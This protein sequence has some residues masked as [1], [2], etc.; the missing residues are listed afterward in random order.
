MAKSQR[1]YLCTWLPCIRWHNVSADF[2]NR[3]FLDTP[4]RTIVHGYIALDV[5]MHLLAHMV[6]G[7]SLGFFVWGECSPIPPMAKCIFWCKWL[8]SIKWHKASY[9]VYVYISLDASSVLN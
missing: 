5:T 1:I 2:L 3:I 4:C 8:C 7:L 9:G 6:S